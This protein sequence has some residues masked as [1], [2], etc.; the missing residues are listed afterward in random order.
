MVA[1]VSMWLTGFRVAIKDFDFPKISLCVLIANHCFSSLKIKYSA[2]PLL[3]DS[4]SEAGF[5]LGRN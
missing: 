1:Y 5:Q 2:K 4:W 3:Q